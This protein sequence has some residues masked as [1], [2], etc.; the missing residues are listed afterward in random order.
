MKFHTD[1][2]KNKI[3]LVD[4]F[5]KSIAN[6]DIISYVKSS[7]WKIKD[8]AIRLIQDRETEKDE[9]YLNSSLTSS[10]RQDYRT[11]E[12][13]ALNII[14]GW[15]VEDAIKDK[16]N[17]LKIKTKNSGTDGNRDFNKFV[18][19]LPDLKANLKSKDQYIEVV[20]G[21]TG[22]EMSDGVSLRDNKYENLLMFNSYL[23]GI[24]LKNEKMFFITDLN[25]RKVGE[26][27]YNSG[28]GK[29]TRTVELKTSDFLDYS[30]GLKKI[31]T[32]LK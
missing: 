24:D 5:T 32:V 21:Y 1:K 25:K 4:K 6:K 20:M 11:T 12:Q 17:M 8:L 2:I 14:L 3:Y 9:Q 7:N 16:L 27:Q 26:K 13:M 18:T 19:N 23:L 31:Q 29:L 15:V 10:H 28:F 30:E 22:R